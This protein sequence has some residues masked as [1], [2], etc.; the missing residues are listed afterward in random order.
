VFYWIYDVPLW[1]GAVLFAIIFVGV[2]W[3]FIILA[4]P[5]VRRLVEQQSNWA[6]VVGSVLSAFGLFYGITLALVVLAAYEDY[7][8][9]GAA[10]GREAAVL[11]TLY[12]DVS[13]Y[14]EPI[15]SELRQMLRAYTRDVIEKDWPAQRQGII[16]EGG[17][18][19]TTAFQ[20]RLLAFKPQARVQEIVHAETLRE[21]ST[22]VEYRRHRL[23]NVTVGLPAILWLVMFAG[24]LLYMVLIALLDVKLLGVHLLVAG[25]PSLFVSLLIFLTVAMDNPYR[26]G[27]SISP[28]GFSACAGE[29]YEA[30]VVVR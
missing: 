9:V 14:P 24:A 12:R 25:I 16:P 18:V 17:T 28:N 20:K 15:R 13:S 1:S 26:G 30:T 29:P 21:F 27:L 6:G 3:L 11:G 23:Q 4:N 5:W 2:T 8:Q 7:S 10:A 22:F 19:Q